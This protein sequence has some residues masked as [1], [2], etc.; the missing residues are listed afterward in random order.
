MLIG[1]IKHNRSVSIVLLPVAMIILWGY[2]FFHPV[3]PLTEHSAP[4]YKLIISGIAFSPFLIKLISFILI[5][6]EALLLYY[7]VKKNEIIPTT[8]YLPSLVYIALMSLQPEM[9]SLHPIVIA[10]LFILLALHKLMQTYRKETAYSEAFSTGFFISLAAL[11]Y[12]PSLV[13]IFLLW[14]GLLIIRPFIWREWVISFI[15]SML[16]WSYLL[17]YYFW[18]D[19]FDALQY[20]ALY[21]T[22]I[23]PSKSFNALTFSYAEELQIGLLLLCVFFASKRFLRDLSKSTVQ[24]RNNLLL[25][26]YFFIFSFASIFIAPEYSIPYLSFLSIPFS[27]FFSSFLLFARKGWIAETLF[28]LLIISIFVNQFFSS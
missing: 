20:D 27:I 1:F 12:I 28:I 7:I 11:F 17:F 3:T 16:P 25:M 4:L 18:N 9:F 5:F 13:F 22:I 15:G 10:N 2:G 24:S 26:L 6:C 8:T 23:A 14:I 19:K 21:Y